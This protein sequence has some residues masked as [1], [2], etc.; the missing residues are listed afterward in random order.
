LK[1][2]TSGES[3]VGRICFE[4]FFERGEIPGRPNPGRLSEAVVSIDA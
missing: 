4:F 2:R 3:T 1:W